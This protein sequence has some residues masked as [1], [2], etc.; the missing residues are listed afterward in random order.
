MKGCGPKKMA[1]GGSVKKSSG[2]KMSPRKALAMGKKPAGTKK[3]AA[4]G[5]V[6]GTVTRPTPTTSRLSFVRTPPR[7]APTTSAT[8]M[9]SRMGPDG[10]MQGYSQKVPVPAS[11]G[12]A[13]NPSTAVTRAPLPNSPT[14]TTGGTGAIRK[15]MAGPAPIRRAKGGMV[16][17][18]CK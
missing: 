14:A 9:G 1:K 17:K 5:L 12:S 18:G 15:P 16:K 6:R 13:P 3:F 11:S 4:G 2:A 10:A 8:I 7:P